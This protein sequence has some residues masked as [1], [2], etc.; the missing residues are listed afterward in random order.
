MAT[1][2][3][4]WKRPEAASHKRG[5]DFC[6]F[7]R[8]PISQTRKSSLIEIPQFIDSSRLI[9]TLFHGLCKLKHSLEI[10]MQMESLA[11]WPREI[12]SP[13][14]SAF[15]RSLDFSWDC[16]KELFNLLIKTWES[17]R[18]FSC[19]PLTEQQWMIHLHKLNKVVWSETLFKIQRLARSV[20]RANIAISR[21]LNW[22][23]RKNKVFMDLTQRH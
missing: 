10:D 20:W 13:D 5:K 19:L 12:Y 22:R 9:A 23:F 7:S 18:F 4:Y 1:A 16:G 11:V 17:L 3:I 6:A 15:T 21:P 14:S 2:E 8:I